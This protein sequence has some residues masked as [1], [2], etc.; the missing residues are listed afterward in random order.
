[1]G[2]C[3]R[4]SLHSIIR[5]KRRRESNTVVYLTCI[6]V[7]KMSLINGLIYDI[8]FY[9]SITVIN[10]AKEN[11]IHCMFDWKTKD[12]LCFKSITQE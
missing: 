5:K 2:D 4:V 3:A 10:C 7:V 12:K 6:F 1:M 9:K 11:C 8:C